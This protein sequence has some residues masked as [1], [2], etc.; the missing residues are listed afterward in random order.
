MTKMTY[1]TLWQYVV[2]ELFVGQYGCLKKRQDHTN[3]AQLMKITNTM[4]LSV[5]KDFFYFSNFPLYF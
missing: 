4:I 3:A 1:L 2:D 5:K